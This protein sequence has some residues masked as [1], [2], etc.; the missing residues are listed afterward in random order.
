MV[1]CVSFFPSSQTM[2]SICRLLSIHRLSFSLSLSFLIPLYRRVPFLYRFKWYNGNN[3]RISISPFT[4]PMHSVF[5][6]SPYRVIYGGKEKRKRN[7]DDCWVSNSR[8]CC[9]NWIHLLVHEAWWRGF[10]KEEMKKGELNLTTDCDHWVIATPENVFELVSS[11]SQSDLRTVHYCF[12][13]IS[14][15]R[16]LTSKNCIFPFFLQHRILFA[17]IQMA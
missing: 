17:R 3:V 10:L 7:A 12:R 5:L 9:A 4:I 1:N 14:T 13:K 15:H 16:F 8:V 6:T 11:C 2:H